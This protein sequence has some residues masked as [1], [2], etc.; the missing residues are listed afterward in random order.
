MSGALYSIISFATIVVL[1]KAMILPAEY[2]DDPVNPFHALS[3][4][5]ITVVVLLVDR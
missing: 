3:K 4:N 5:D 2:E 1:S